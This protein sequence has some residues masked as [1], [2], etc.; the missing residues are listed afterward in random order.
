MDVLVGVAEPHLHHA[1]DT[2]CGGRDEL[3]AA[4]TGLGWVLH[5]R[6]A[7]AGGGSRQGLRANTCQVRHSSGGE[8]APETNEELL[9]LVHRQLALDFCEPQHANDCAMSRREQEMLQ[10]QQA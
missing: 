6:D 3:W 4:C 5:G 10:R 7:G 1:F 9:R 8:G 2:R